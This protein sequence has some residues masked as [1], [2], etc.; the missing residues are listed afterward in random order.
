MNKQID[1]SCGFEELRR[2]LGDFEEMEKWE[3]NEEIGRQEEIE[4]QLPTIQDENR[5]DSGAE[6]LEREENGGDQNQNQTQQET[7]D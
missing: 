6:F 3:E 1:L 5:N 4:N 7:N 2:N